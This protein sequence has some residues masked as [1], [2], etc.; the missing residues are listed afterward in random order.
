ML[1]GNALEVVT[2]KVL[3][4]VDSDNFCGQGR[5]NLSPIGRIM[6]EDMVIHA[7]VS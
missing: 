7:K 1:G 6:T 4:K 2:K 3:T 5:K